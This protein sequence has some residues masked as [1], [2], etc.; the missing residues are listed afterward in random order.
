MDSALLVAIAV[1][2]V[3]VVA[4]VATRSPAALL[5][6]AAGIGAAWVLLAKTSNARYTGGEEAPRPPFALEDFE[7]A[8]ATGFSSPRGDQILQE[9]CFF[10]RVAPGA[11]RI[12]DATA[13]V[14]V[15]S[16]VLAHSFP[17]A[18]IT[19]IEYDPDVYKI[20]NANLERHGY[21]DRVDA[22][23]ESSADYFLRHGGEPD[24][25]L[26]YFDPPWGGPGYKKTSDL[27]LRSSQGKGVPV[28][29]VVNAVLGS[30]D[31]LV[32]LK[33]PHN[34]DYRAFERRLK[35]FVT[36]VARI[37]YPKAPAS[38]RAVFNLLEIRK[39]ACRE[40]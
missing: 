4:A 35:G 21:S 8:E 19:A 13:H 9:I 18:K 10:R 39:R 1:L 33:T 22:L 24:A 29:K 36:G 17:Q 2:L 31:A 5:L 28:S 12:V 6:A 34:F 32:V 23:N 37:V 25:D 40:G 11:R 14:G 27:Y 7:W 15:D 38:G 16:A 30:S 3:I 20:L 26:V